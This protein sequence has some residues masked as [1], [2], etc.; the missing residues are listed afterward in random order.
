M[1]K[2]V[3]FQKALRRWRVGLWASIGLFATAAQALQIST[4]SPQ[5]E[6]AQVRQVLARF[7]EP[8]VTFG[9]PAAPAE[10]GV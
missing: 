4:L 1:N 9:D 10:P 8:A 3:P 5:G 7:D 6:V 2:N